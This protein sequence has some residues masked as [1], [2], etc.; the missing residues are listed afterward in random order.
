LCSSSPTGL[1]ASRGGSGLS[2]ILSSS[3]EIS[4]IAPSSI[5]SFDLSFKGMVTCPLC[6]TRTLDNSNHSYTVG[7]SNLKV[8]LL[9]VAGMV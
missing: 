4:R 2:T 9:V 7:E 8:L 1:P 3:V 5:L 6:L